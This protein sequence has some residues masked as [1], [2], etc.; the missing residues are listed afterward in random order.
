MVESIILPAHAQTGFVCDAPERCYTV[1][2]FETSFEWPG[3]VGLDN[4]EFFN[5]SVCGGD[6]RGPSLLVVAE[7]LAATQEALP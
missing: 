3:G 4:A 5:G 6:E 1:P 2:S 7:S